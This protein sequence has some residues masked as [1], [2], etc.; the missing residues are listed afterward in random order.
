MSKK[1][2]R[3]TANVV[4]NAAPK[5]APRPEAA[6]PAVPPRLLT[7]RDAQ[8]VGSFMQQLEAR[9]K[10]FNL[11]GDQP[12]E[13]APEPSEDELQVQRDAAAIF[14]TD[15]GARLLEWLADRTVRT[16]LVVDPLTVDPVRGWAL[17]QRGEGRNDTFF[18]ILSLIAAARE[19]PAPRRDGPQS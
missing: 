2:A 10:N 15:A 19:E 5:P 13:E 17:A 9:L 3:R 11:F 8:P 7:A 18:L 12:A 4:A 1:S 16:A 6:T 14:A